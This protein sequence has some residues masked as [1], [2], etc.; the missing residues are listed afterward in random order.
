MLD[1]DKARS[2]RAAKRAEKAGSEATSDGTPIVLDGETI[3]VLPPELPFGVI[4]P[5]DKVN[6]EIALLL[7]QAMRMQSG[8]QAVDG[9][10]L[11]LDLFSAN[12]AL[13]K[14]LIDIVKGVS[15]ALLSE[16]GLRKFL[17]AEP[18]INDIAA[19][20]GGIFEIYGRAWGN[21][22]GPSTRPRA[23]DRSPSRL[24]TVLR[25]RRPRSLPRPWRSPGI[26]RSPR[27]PRPRRRPAPVRGRAAQHD[28]RH[29]LTGRSGRPRWNCSRRPS[30][31]S[32]S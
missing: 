16:Q 21:P 30:R 18:S 20:I 12:A 13:P 19:L 8:G 5:F 24:P 32:P 27:L 3:A 17:D 1:L 22:R 7:G 29:P 6:D 25:P 14:L 9:T 11:V 28:V 31:P 23:M 4:R 26:H 2:Q 10:R 15:T